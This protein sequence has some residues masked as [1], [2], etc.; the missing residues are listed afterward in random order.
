MNQ[1]TIL[2]QKISSLPLAPG[3]GGDIASARKHFSVVANQGDPCGLYWLGR[4]YAD[5]RLPEHNIRQSLEYFTQAA[6]E[7]YKPAFLEVARFYH[8]GIG[9]QA[10]LQDAIEYY[11][12][13]LEGSNIDDIG[14]MVLLGNANTSLKAIEF[15]SS[16]PEGP[17]PDAYFEA[18]WRCLEGKGVT[19]SEENAFQ[20]FVHAGNR[21]H[22]P[23]LL[24]QAKAHMYGLLG[25]SQDADKAIA[26]I[27]KLVSN[28]DASAICNLGICFWRGL[29]VSP[30]QE[31]AIQAWVKSAQLDRQYMGYSVYSRMLNGE[32]KN[33]YLLAVYDNFKYAAS[34]DPWACF[35]FKEFE[36]LQIWETL[37]KSGIM[38]KFTP[39]I[40]QNLADRFEEYLRGEHSS[41]L[42]ARH[43]IRKA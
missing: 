16:A 36:K 22:I 27:K 31:Q 2:Y 1:M 5:T 12:L 7:N 19:P 9:M 6:R 26:I 3:G 41:L 28:G 37:S 32:Y 17:Y 39:G 35:L 34:I 4:C 43:H 29:G 38:S 24:S 40:K 8:V 21:G 11:L 14:L 18:A 20:F 23:S 33:D 10:S 30:S 15:L 25:Q 42:L 13:A